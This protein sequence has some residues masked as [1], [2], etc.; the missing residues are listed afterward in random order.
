MEKFSAKGRK[1]P[2]SDDG[3]VL[4]LDCG[5]DCTPRKFTRNH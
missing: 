3:H 5:D 2:F 1:G 4:E